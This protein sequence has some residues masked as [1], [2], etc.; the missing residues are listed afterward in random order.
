MTRKRQGGFTLLE[1]L[2]SMVITIFGLMGL[3]AMH[4][5]LSAG[6]DLAAQTQEGVTVGLQLVEQLRSE[7]VADMMK[8]LTGSSTSALPQTITDY[9]PQVGRNGLQYH[10]D[11]K[12]TQGP[13]ATLWRVRVEVYWG[14]DNASGTAAQH[15]IPFEVIR[16]NL[17]QL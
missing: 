10:R 14:E 3:L 11:V 4:T 9:S 15:R 16:S 5:S 7:R 1:M 12:V 6:T 8:A 17:E 13:S 2:I